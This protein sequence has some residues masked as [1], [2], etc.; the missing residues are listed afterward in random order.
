MAKLLIRPVPFQE[1]SLQQY[2]LRLAR[3]NGY[4]NKSAGELI[5]QVSGI[6]IHTYMITHREE[7]K[8]KL[9]RITGHNEVQSLFDHKLWYKKYKKVFNY[10]RI[11]LCPLCLLENNHCHS[12]WHFRHALTCEKHKTLLIDTCWSCLRVLS[13]FS[14]TSMVCIFCGVEVLPKI[15]RKVTFDNRVDNYF[16]PY[17]DLD[18]LCNKIDALK[19][20]FELYQEKSYQLWAKNNSYSIKDRITLI[21]SVLDIFNSKQ[22]TIHAIDEL[23]TKSKVCTSISIAILRVNVYLSHDKYPDFT[24]LFAER[25]L[26]ISKFFPSMTIPPSLVER[27]YRINVA[28]IKR[29]NIHSEPLYKEL[30]MISLQ[31]RRYVLFLHK[32]PILLKISGYKFS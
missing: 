11:K 2:I 19:P 1:E 14:L 23:M 8:I 4:T 25:L 9:V 10:D 3:S 22:L 7:L 15:N 5:K 12:Y 30:G 29:T 28:K 31:S 18:G 16:S 24:R 6:P 26:I 17:N 32:L 13:E 20:Y 21:N 27:L